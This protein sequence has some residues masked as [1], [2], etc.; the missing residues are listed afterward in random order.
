MCSTHS[1]AF[2]GPLP[3][4]D[5]RSLVGCERPNVLACRDCRVEVLAKCG[6]TRSIVCEPCGD[7]HRARVSIV[8]GSGM[9]PR[10]REFAGRRMVL[11]THGLFVT[12]TAP[13]ARAHRRPDGRVC[14]CTPDG[15]TDIAKWN[16]ESAKRFNRFMQEVRRVYGKDVEYFKGAEVQKRGALHFHL[17]VRRRNGGPLAL[18]V[19]HLRTLAIHYGFG[20][21]IDIQKYDVKHSRYVAK[22]VAKSSNERGSVPW[23]GV[24]RRVWEDANLNT[25]ESERRVTLVE[26][27]SPSYRTWTASRCWGDPMKLVRA[28]QGHFNDLMREL[29]SWHASSAGAVLSASLDRVPLRP[30]RPDDPPA[31]GPMDL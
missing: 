6:S 18:N 8:A 28:A 13:G 26:S 27:R 25:G 12:L 15:G 22:Y 21:S 31:A 30:D 16:A 10:S 1:W 14:E 17:I 20:H 7:A 5:S 23:D 11:A 29:P 19:G 4:G 2:L 24:R 3:E 9:H